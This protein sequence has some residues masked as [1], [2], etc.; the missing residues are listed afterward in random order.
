MCFLSLII[1][2]I[3][4]YKTNISTVAQNVVLLF[5]VYPG[6]TKQSQINMVINMIADHYMLLNL[7]HLAFNLMKC[8]LFFPR[9]AKDVGLYFSLFLFLFP[10]RK[11]N[12][13]FS[14][15]HHGWIKQRWEP[16]GQYKLSAPG[17]HTLHTVCVTRR[18]AR[19]RR[20][21]SRALRHSQ[22]KLTR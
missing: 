7:T 19:S 4:I 2:W 21:D 12:T 3:L 11:L 13:F 16:C 5:G 17:D 1:T 15:P 14:P 20:E 8:S 22:S 9:D 10:N 18:P 6:I